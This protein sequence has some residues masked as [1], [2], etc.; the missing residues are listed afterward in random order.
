M[1]IRI[2]YQ[3]R[4]E[5]TPRLLELSPEDYFD[6]LDPGQTLSVRSIPR[7]LDT[8]Q[9]TPYRADELCWTVVEICDGAS[10]WRVRTQLL[11][12]MRSLMHH[13]QQSDGS[14]EIIH[15]TELG[16]QCWHTIRTLKQPGR[17]WAVVVNSLLVEGSPVHLVES[18]GFCGSY[19]FEELKA[20]GT[21]Q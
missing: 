3:L 11:D 1:E 20:I 8:Y 6:P 16:P 4:T 19:S 10:F 17:S 18:R 15:A 5:P 2:R 13:S 21:M 14:E 12:G 7:L 9:Y